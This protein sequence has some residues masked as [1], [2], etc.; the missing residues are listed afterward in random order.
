MDINFS[1]IY[2]R[3]FP[4]AEKTKKQQ[5]WQVLCESFFQKYIDPNESV[6][7]LGA[8]YCEFIN[9][10]KATH[11]IAIDLNPDTAKYANSDVQ[12]YQTSSTDLSMIHE[13]SI[14]VVFASNFFEHLPSKADLVVTLRSIW[15]VLRVEG[16]LLILQ[17][18]IRF[19]HGEYWDFLDHYLPLTDRSLVEALNLTGF[20]PVE[21]KPK[22]LPYST[23]SPLPQSPWLVRLYLCIPA[24]H[25]LFGKQSWIVAVKPKSG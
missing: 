10:I 21:V 3:R 8:G 19:L 5:L 11:K 4:P 13:A 18:N 7:D 2:S 1:Q 14:D 25:Y 15:R 6:L 20:L 24:A 23:K 22:F 17:P 16:R 9:H 12:V